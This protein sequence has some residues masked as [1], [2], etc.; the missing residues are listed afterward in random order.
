[1]RGYGTIGESEACLS[2][3]LSHPGG[4]GPRPPDTVCT[5]WTAVLLLLVTAIIVQEW[6]CVVGGSQQRITPSETTWILK[7][8][9]TRDQVLAKFGSPH[10]TERTGGAGTYD[11]Y[12][13]HAPGTL[14]P[15]LRPSGPSVLAFP[16]PRE[17]S[18]P[19]VATNRFWL[20]YDANGQVED[21]G[22]DNP[23]K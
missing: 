18:S 23:S 17:P 6:G 5:M 4:L 15:Q 8:E 2:C 1:M 7:G 13:Y 9:T 19:E 10:L 3:Q 22:F 14:E 11:E 16:P 21:F 20:R 12:T